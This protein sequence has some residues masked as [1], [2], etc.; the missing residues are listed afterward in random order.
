MST[1]ARRALV[2]AKHPLLDRLIAEH[3][4]NKTAEEIGRLA[5]CS[6]NYVYA[7]ASRMG[8]TLRK[9]A[10]RQMIGKLI[11]RYAGMMRSRDIAAKAGVSDSTVR[12]VASEMGISLQLGHRPVRA[13]P[14]VPAV[15]R[16][17]R[18]PA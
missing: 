17:L 10:D 4:T 7:R 2:G 1:A 15:D 5:G 8:I 13:R 11:E 16:F 9:R 14:A 6:R 18:M 12:A 3:A